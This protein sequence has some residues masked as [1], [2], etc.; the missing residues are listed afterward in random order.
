MKD[1]STIV[2]EWVKKNPI[3]KQTHC[4]SILMAYPY[5]SEGEN[6]VVIYD[7]LA[8]RV[9]KTQHQ[10]HSLRLVERN[11]YVEQGIQWDY[12]NN[13]V[14]FATPANTYHGVYTDYDPKKGMLELSTVAIDAHR[15]KVNKDGK[16][17]RR[18]WR[19]LSR[20]FFFKG[21][22]DTY[23]AIGGKTTTPANHK[24]NKATSAYIHSLSL[25]S[26]GYY[27]NIQIAKDFTEFTDHIVLKVNQWSGPTMCTR[28]WLF[29]CFYKSYT[30]KR[31][32]KDPLGL[33]EINAKL[34]EVENEELQSFYEGKPL[35]HDISILIFQQVN[36][37]LAVIRKFTKMQHYSRS[38]GTYKSTLKEWS[39]VFITVKGQVK[40]FDGSDNTWYMRTTKVNNSY[41]EQYFINRQDIYGF[42]PLKYIAPLIP[43]DGDKNILNF[44]IN[45]L[46]HPVIESFAKAGY[47]SIAK[48]LSN[49]NEVASNL[50]DIFGTE[51]ED[52]NIYK[53]SGLNKYQL[54]KIEG[55]MGE[56]NRYYQPS[57]KQFKRL[58]DNPQAIDDKT[59]EL[60]L[61]AIDHAGNQGV[62]KLEA[63]LYRYNDAG[64][65]EYC[66]RLWW[67][68]E[69]NIITEFQ[70]QCL[71]KL[72]KT[73]EKSGNYLLYRVFADTVRLYCQIS[74]DN[75]P[76]F[77]LYELSPEQI[78]RAHD[79]LIDLSN[80]EKAKQ[81]LIKQKTQQERLDKI[82]KKRQEKFEFLNDSNYDYII[83]TPKKPVE[84]V[85]EGAYLHH[86]VGGYV[87][88]VCNGSTNI[89]FLRKKSEPTKPFYTI[90]V[91][92]QNRLIQVH[93]CCNKWLGN[94]PE[95]IPFMVD[96]LTKAEIQFD[97]S[98]L[99]CCATGYGA[100][101]AKYLDAATYGL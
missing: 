89:L 95:A 2:K 45:A 60:V 75:R 59:S 80:D 53:A 57:I 47:P 23:D 67:R 51:K 8:N 33:A 101:G 16:V 18:E 87:E 97:K 63:F 6:K 29:E 9:M 37:K 70:R 36:D 85:N 83:I 48:R 58:F 69:P 28:L 82:N 88:D 31:E 3:P 86:C 42:L 34:E 21:E 17:E 44:I 96:W 72:F 61:S 71:L 27:N 32:H 74:D 20:R 62:N 99:L 10:Y 81:D 91:N 76:D 30:I 52:K 56:A 22:I 65:I 35:S 19:F 90:E 24:Y 15:P 26:A 39:R 5:K 1:Y 77:K 7:L 49:Y 11:Y 38:E 43:T 41:T 84:V 100:S 12:Y 78:S 46:R 98:I 93:G 64:I 14:S 94:D 4:P 13:P 50:K 68:E 54:K 40:V 66:N 55:Y 25:S 92:T 73:I 79:I